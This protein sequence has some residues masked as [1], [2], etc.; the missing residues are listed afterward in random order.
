MCVDEPGEAEW[1]GLHA[2]KGISLSLSAAAV[3]CTCEMFLF[4]PPDLLPKGNYRCHR[5]SRGEERAHSASL[6]RIAL[7]HILLSPRR[8]RQG[9]WG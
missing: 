9:S 1:A 8:E 5:D 4:F 6:L 3:L 2:P 7:L